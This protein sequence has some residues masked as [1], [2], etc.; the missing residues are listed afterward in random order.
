METCWNENQKTARVPF[1][2]KGKNMLSRSGTVP[3]CGTVPAG[4]QVLIDDR[5]RIRGEVV[6][7]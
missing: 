3:L 7:G 2:G 5:L 6:C 1:N 4:T